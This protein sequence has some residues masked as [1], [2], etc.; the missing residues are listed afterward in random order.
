MTHLYLPTPAEGERA[1]YQTQTS[2][3]RADWSL[4][5]VFVRLMIYGDISQDARVGIGGVA[6][7]PFR[8][9][10]VESALVGQPATQETFAT[11]LTRSDVLPR[12]M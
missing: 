5:E 2:R 6:N 7:I 3:I 10:E 9:T 1:S 8:L 11:A 12:S 4:V